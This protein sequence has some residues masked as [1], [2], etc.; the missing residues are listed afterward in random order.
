[1]EEDKKNIFLGQN[2]PRIHSVSAK[3]NDKKVELKKAIFTS[4]KKNKNCPAWSIK[5]D[6]ITHDRVNQNIHYKNAILNIYDVP[7]FYFPKFFHPDPSVERRSG[8]L[9]PRLNNSNVLG[10]SL[11]LPYFHVI[12]D[13]KDIT[14]KPTIFDDKIYMFQN[15]YRQENEKSSFIADFSYTKGYQSS[16]VGDG[17]RNSISHLFSKFDLNLDL[18]LH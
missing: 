5:A 16:V 7:V 4:C 1:M 14:F 15:E 8:L 9:Q 12:S 18:K 13:N 10:S 6:K 17:N 2:D 11:N 3:G